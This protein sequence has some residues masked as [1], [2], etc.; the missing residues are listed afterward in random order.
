LLEGG[1]FQTRLA[2][3]GKGKG[4][5]PLKTLGGW[6]QGGG[7]LGA[8]E[9]RRIPQP[10]AHPEKRP[11]GCI[12][13]FPFFPC[14]PETKKTRPGQRLYRWH[15]GGGP[16]VPR[17]GKVVLSGGGGAPV[18]P[19]PRGGGMGGGLWFSFGPEGPTR[20][21][22]LRWG[23]ARPRTVCGFFC[24][25]GKRGGGHPLGL[26]KPPGWGEPGGGGRNPLGGGPCWPRGG[27]KKQ[28]FSRGGGLKG[29][30]GLG[31]GGG[32]LAGVSGRS[33]VGPPR[34]GGGKWG[35]G[36]AAQVGKAKKRGGGF[37]GRFTG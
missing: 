31:P 13:L 36:G 14:K 37:L 19:P 1:D 21:E 24:P 2:V 29:G 30:G 25:P 26:L 11:P 8:P 6:G 20:G 22:F 33:M 16:D 9:N 15:P 23:G 28:T 18:F 5:P 7:L 4:G 34:K 27:G 32:P 35:R 3:V 10:P 12:F 17:K